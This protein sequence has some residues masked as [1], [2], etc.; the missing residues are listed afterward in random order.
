[1]EPPGDDGASECGYLGI[2]TL[3]INIGLW[4]EVFGGGMGEIRNPSTWL[5][6][7]LLI[8]MVW[9]RGLLPPYFLS[10]S[11]FDDGM[12]DIAAFHISDH[13]TH[14]VLFIWGI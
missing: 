5:E 10:V 3:V 7:G 8:V 11:Y 9:K 14:H 6:E 12:G 4:S 1:M 2:D 13:S